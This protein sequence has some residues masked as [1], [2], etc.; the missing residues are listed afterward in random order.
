MRED[1]HARPTGDAPEPLYDVDVSTPTHAERARTLVGQISTGTLCTLA[2]EPQGYPYGS[3]VTVAFDFSQ[4]RAITIRVPAAKVGP[5]VPKPGPEVPQDVRVSGEA[6]LRLN[7]VQDHAEVVQDLLKAAAGYDV[8]F[9]AKL[10]V[11]GRNQQ[12][13]DDKRLQRSTSPSPQ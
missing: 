9:C 6:M 12:R 7:Q 1:A 2:L 3:F 10:Q 8:S 13:P 11:R 5:E 4:A